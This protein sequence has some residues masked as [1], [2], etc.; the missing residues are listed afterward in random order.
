MGLKARLAL[1]SSSAFVLLV[2]SA[3]EAAAAR[4]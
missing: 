2:V 1:I 4:F 3:L